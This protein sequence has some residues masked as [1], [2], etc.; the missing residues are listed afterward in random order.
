[1]LQFSMADRLAEDLPNMLEEH[2][3]IVAALDKLKV[4]AMAE[5][6]QKQVHF[7]E[8]L[9]LHAKNEE[10]IL[11]PAA[12]LIGKYLKRDSSSG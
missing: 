9:I 12:I 5:N 4:A 3:A 1:M 10:D 6:K 2:K 7:A 8:K 11:Y